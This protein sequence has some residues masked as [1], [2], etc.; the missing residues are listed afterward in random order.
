MALYDAATSLKY[1]R[2]AHRA[3]AH[4]VTDVI[5]LSF[6]TTR[7]KRTRDQLTVTR[8]TRSNLEAAPSRTA[9][10]HPVI[11]IRPAADDSLGG[12]VDGYVQPDTGFRDDEGPE[13][14]TAF[15]NFDF[16]AGGL[17]EQLLQEEAPSAFDS[18]RAQMH[19]EYWKS[20]PANIVMFQGRKEATKVSLLAAI[21]AHGSH[22][23]R[24]NNMDLHTQEP[25]VSVLWVGASYR[26]ELAVPRRHCCV[27][28]H[29]FSLKPL[30]LGC[31]P[32]TAVQGWD[33]TK[34]VFGGRPM[35]FDL[36]LL[37]V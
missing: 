22:C 27:C 7:H 20:L 32:A 30:Q 37:Q 11:N 23:P 16:N 8:V 1:D 19:A 2:S 9:R 5:M 29:S 17:P 33:L 14:G 18:I 28:Q 24:C 35:W 34:V 6:F 4:A 21:A 31:L 13:A 12:F 15:H 25:A 10:P 36:Q 3:E 26:F